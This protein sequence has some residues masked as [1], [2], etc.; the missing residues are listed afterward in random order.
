MTDV[1]EGKKDFRNGSTEAVT[2]SAE[3]VVD[4][5]AGDISLPS[6]PPS[7]KKLLSL[8][9]P[10]WAMLVVAV[11]LMT[12]S[13]ATSLWIPII[14]A[15]A[16]NALVDPTMEQEGRTDGGRLGTINRVM[17]LTLVC[18]TIGVVCSFL[19]S[20][21]M[22]VA[23]ERIVA[24]LRNELYGRL[25]TQEIA[26]YDAAKTGELISRLSS[27]T[28]LIQ[29]ATSQALPEI[30]LGSIKL[31]VC[32]VI[33]FWLSASLAATTLGWTVIIFIIC[34]FFGKILGNLS[35]DY[36]DA[37]S[38][39][40]ECSTEALGG[41]RTVQSFC[42]EDRE[43]KR[44]ISHI[45]RPQD[46]P[47]WVPKA[48][49]KTTYSTGYWK[50]IATSG[51]FTAIFGLGFGGMYVTLWYGFH[52]VNQGSMSLGDLT[53]FQSYIFLIGGS[54]AQTAQFLS[55]TIEA[56]GASGR[57]FYLLEREPQIPSRKDING[58]SI[59]VA[60]QPETMIGSVEFHCVDF[61]Y[62]TR[63]DVAVL[64]K[65]SLK[66]P[67][68]TTAALVG[69]SG[70]GKSTVASLLQR[71]YDV[72]AGTITIDGHDIRHLNLKWLRK[73]IAYVQQEPQLFGLTVRENVCYGIDRPVSEKE[74]T[75]VCQEANAH[76]F[77][78]QWPQAYETLVGERGVKLSGGQ[79]QRI[80]IARA[81]LINP[82]ILLLD[83]ATSALDSESEALVQDAIEKAMVGRTVLIVA[84][85]LSTI[86]RAA[87]IVVLD[88]HQ[89]VDMGTHDDLML[90]CSKYQDLIQKQSHNLFE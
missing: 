29:Q 1:E 37:L 5:P 45:G 19:R 26:F 24:R 39:A 10:E 65:F 20:S 15:Q 51:F 22:S 52:L 72:T 87:Q 35:K 70:A 58:T 74:L 68:N 84:H 86:R 77:I 56:I 80:A 43:Q 21:I 73:H 11:V 23:G 81:L 2:M 71:F 64:N 31:L 75:D 3:K 17:I 7:F 46:F 61:S 25:L 36:Q 18:H 55:Q 4:S 16:Y 69:S 38:R 8:G 88:Q 12:A 44:Y 28:A 57:I 40:Q 50:S 60:S 30:L 53:A 14:I 27:D 66:I 33:M 42:S 9:R 79:K 76:D 47:W 59:E 6:S 13:E 78:I 67:P 83:E 63:P 90:R 89:I 32:L 41:M 62:P 82:K 54:L 49:P 48:L 85:R 34:L